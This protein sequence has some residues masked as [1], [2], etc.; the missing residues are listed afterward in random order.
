MV[1]RNII[2]SNLN[3]QNFRCSFFTT[4][5]PRTKPTFFHDNPSSKATRN[6]YFHSN[7]KTFPNMNDGSMIIW[8]QM[9]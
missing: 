7:F 6:K 4:I 2:Q 8:V 9:R 1:A 3:V 5:G